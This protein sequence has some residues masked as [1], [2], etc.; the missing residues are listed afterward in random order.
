ME[1]WSIGAFKSP[2][3]PRGVLRQGVRSEPFEDAVILVVQGLGYEL[4]TFVGVLPVASI[5]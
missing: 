2:Q 4:Q 5:L 1:L 3:V